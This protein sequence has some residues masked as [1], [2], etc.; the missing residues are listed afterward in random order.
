MANWIWKMAGTAAAVAAASAAVMLADKLMQKQQDKINAM[1]RENT[2]DAAPAPEAET[3][4]P[5][6]DETA[7]PAQPVEPAEQAPEAEAPE[8]KPE[9]EAPVYP[10]PAAGEDR[11]NPNPVMAGPAEKPLTTDGKIDVSKLCDPADFCDWDAFG[12]RD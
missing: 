2:P 1:I 10:T 6:Q 12:C 7:Q 11:P 9:P 4:T 3:E 8:H 5:A